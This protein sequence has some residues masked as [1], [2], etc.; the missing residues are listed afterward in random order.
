MR[1][2]VLKSAK[3]SDLVEMLVRL[4]D[5]D[6]VVDFCFAVEAIFMAARIIDLGDWLGVYLGLT[7]REAELLT[8]LGQ[9]IAP[10][11]AAEKMG[12]SNETVRTHT[13]N[14]YRKLQVSDRASAVAIAW[15]EGLVR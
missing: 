11:V 10:R 13:R 5:G 12:L 1:G 6:V 14:L 7:R 8:L 2:Y 4:R 15:R 9:G 3:P